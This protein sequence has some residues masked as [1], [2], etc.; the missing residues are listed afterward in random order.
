MISPN[1][2]NFFIFANV[3]LGGG[4]TAL[5]CVHVPQEGGLDT[6]VDRSS[7]STVGYL[8]RTSWLALSARKMQQKSEFDELTSMEKY[9]Q[10][11]LIKH[12]WKSQKIDKVGFYHFIL[13][14]FKQFYLEKYTT[15]LYKFL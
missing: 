8:L 12:I 15:T 9:T 3:F 6:G 11:L 5:L 4:Y 2:V 1:F 13:D 14:K 7:S 10:L